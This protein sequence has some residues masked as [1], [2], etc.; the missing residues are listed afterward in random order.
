MVQLGDRPFVLHVAGIQRRGW[1]E[2]EDVRFFLGDRPMF[3]ATGN[4]QNLSLFE[5]DMPI[6]ELHAE[7]ALHDEE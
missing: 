2:H 6:P 4:N 3:D 7:A 1:L 5:P